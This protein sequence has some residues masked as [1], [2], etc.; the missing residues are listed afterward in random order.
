[1]DITR[2]G[3]L[4]LLAVVVGSV[5]ARASPVTLPLP[6]V[7]IAL[8][9]IIGAITNNAI[10]LRPDVFFLLFVPP[11][12]FLDGWR[13]NKE[14]LL[15]DK[16]TILALALGLVAFTVLGAG[17]FIA[18]MIPAM[19]L[20]VAFALA[21]TLSPTDPVAVSAIAARVPISERVI[22]ILEGETLFN[23]AS[24]LV[25]MRFAVAAILTGTFSLIEVARTFLWV[26][27]GGVAIG[28][29]VTWTVVKAKSWLV[30][31]LGEETGSQILISLLIPFG[32]YLVAEHFRCSGILS[33]VAAGITMSHAEQ[34]GLAL[35][36][37][38]VRR[39]VVWDAVQFTANGVIFVLLGE[40][41]PHIVAGAAH[42]VRDT[43]HHE[44]AWLL[45]Y[46][47]AINTVLS[48]L[49]FLWV[50]ASLRLTLLR[51]AWT[52]QTLRKAC[53]RMI[54]VISLGGARG[55]VTLAGA[56]TLPM[57]LNDG[58]PFPT[59]DLAV[60]L[61]AGVI[62]CSL[63]AASIGLPVV[64]KGLELLPE[65]SDQQEEDWARV[66]AAEA[67]IR[68]VEHVVRDHADLRAGVYEEVAHHVIELYRHRIN[69]RSKVGDE[70]ALL[71]KLDS[72][73][74]QLRI[75]GIHAERDTLYLLGRTRRI[76]DDV[77]R[78]LVNELD[79]AENQL[80]ST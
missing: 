32:A 71:R 45:V 35:P 31:R 65:V 26:A 55:A 77:V 40:Q 11:L 58:S 42:V 38:R 51:A 44:V 6:L 27:I 68:A 21:A 70:A 5:L 78:K 69:T 56:L 8:G 50:W 52:R 63:I 12:L 47:L 1:M 17:L 18:W 13:I 4:L 10:E 19:P 64:L 80:V 14:R 57:A 72:F 15:Q 36:T 39:T 43:H 41:L 76:S 16:G 29:A 62:A 9:A 23:D 49:R 73:E 37:T 46:I 79:L 61:A 30:R 28:V 53:W 54:A 67:A 22:H 7:Q 34:S 59:R 66:A 3:L 33:A 20:G 74:R 75:A 2:S 25:C 24:G 48:M 60:L